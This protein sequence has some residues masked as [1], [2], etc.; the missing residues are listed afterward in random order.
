MSP[1][2]EFEYLPLVLRERGPAWFPQAPQP[3]N[4]TTVDNKTNRSTHAGGLKGHCSSISTNW[5]TRQTTRSTNGLPSIVAGIPL[6]LRID[7]SLDL[8]ELRRQFSFEIVSEQE[9]GFVIVASEDVNLAD[10][11]QKLDDFV[12]SVSGSS[13]VAK[14]HE[15]RE[16]LTQEE[17]LRLILTDT[18]LQEWS[19]VADDAIYICDV[20]ITCVGNW[21]VPNKPS[22][23]PRW[24]DETWAR[25]ENAWSTARL[26]AYDKWDT[27]KDDRLAAIHG[28][29][30]HYQ[31][32]I[33]MDVDNG[34]AEALTLPDSFTLRLKISG[35][36]L[37]DLVL[38]YP[39][40]FASSPESV[41]EFWFW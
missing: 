33:L 27:L 18:L 14:I 15:L 25:K 30:D 32:E 1:T 13:N 8:D 9:N 37:K 2:H 35:K 7:T 36:G 21:E 16:D 12:G 39:Y 20:S 19:T 40:I 4:P 41:G 17:R 24:K 31:A 6:L 34:D 23:N 29:I 3:E 22:R 26:D 28:I 5:Q 38:S 11:R 10:F